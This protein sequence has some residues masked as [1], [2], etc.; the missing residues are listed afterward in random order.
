MPW[1]K[2]KDPY[3]IWVSEILLQQT[4]VETVKP[5]YSRFIK[6]FPTVKSLAEAPLDRVLKMWEGCGYYARARNLH[7]A[8]KV[9]AATG[10]KVPQTS[11]ELRELPGIGP[12]TAAA[13]A[14]I[15]YGEPVAV[16]D[17][18]VERVLARVLCEKRVLKTTPVLKRIRTV[19]DAMM[20]LANKSH[21]PPADFNQ[22]LMELGATLCQPK[23]AQCSSCPLR[24]D[25]RARATLA[26]VTLLPRKIAKKKTPHY[27]IGAA[28]IRKNG[29][30]LIT[31]RPLDGLL[32]G[33]WEFPGGKV[34]LN[35][36]LEECVEREIRE[37]L[38]I[39]ITVGQKL[40]SVDHAYSHFSITLHCFYCTHRSG[41]IKKIGVSDYRWVGVDELDQ[42][43][44]PKADRIVLQRIKEEGTKKKARS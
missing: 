42:F 8:A 37:E 1:R 12:Y 10:G 7:K 35:E 11:S 17:G 18:N 24:T 25:C 28:I 33:L 9:V 19:A 40:I 22:A 3:K 13:I 41:R 4:Q 31:Q 16:V 20:A 36:T 30:I 29:K 38:A 21:I 26:D 44:F 14:S 43:A 32:G 27:H 5:Y 34:D 23:R 2:T 39:N 15:A 6:A